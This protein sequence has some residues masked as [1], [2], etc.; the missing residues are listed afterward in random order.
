MKN[1]MN[2]KFF[3]DDVF[4]QEFVRIKGASYCKDK[5]K[6]YKLKK[7]AASTNFDDFFAFYEEFKV[8]KPI[9]LNIGSRVLL[10][11]Y[12]VLTKEHI[13]KLTNIFNKYE[14]SKMV[15]SL[16]RYDLSVIIDW[17]KEYD[18]Y[19]DETTA[20][21]LALNIHRHLNLPH[22]YRDLYHFRWNDKVA[23]IFWSFGYFK[24]K[25]LFLMCIEKL[26][27]TQD[28]YKQNEYFVGYDI[29]G[30]CSEQYSFAV[31]VLL[32]AKEQLQKEKKEALNLFKKYSYMY[33]DLPKK[34]QDDNDFLFEYLRGGYGPGYIDIKIQKLNLE[35][36]KKI[37]NN[38]ELWTRLVIDNPANLI[39]SDLELDV[40][41]VVSGIK[42]NVKEKRLKQEF[43]GLLLSANKKE[44]SFNTKNNKKIMPSKKVYFK[45]KN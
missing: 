44:E 14:I 32:S 7:I 15:G 40:D 17:P 28:I 24:L 18:K 33:F 35:S 30:K 12:Q 13:E 9:L 19:I 16:V 22:L 25:E 38:K 11:C 39:C 1:D 31:N 20:R 43:G 27:Q 5:V 10:E 2:E 37:M 4:L 36:R 8:D 34:Y 41:K 42:E 45:F 3:N 21:Y 26:K 6:S 29:L 23:F